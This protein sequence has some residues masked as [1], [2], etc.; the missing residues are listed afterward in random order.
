M[1]RCIPNINTEVSWDSGIRYHQQH[2][3]EVSTVQEF[4][5][6]RHLPFSKV[7]VL[8]NPLFVKVQK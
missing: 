2:G 8:L 6:L 1:L 5:I 4:I 7:C 3:T